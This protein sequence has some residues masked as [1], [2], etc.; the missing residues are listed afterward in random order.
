MLTL[1]HRKDGPPCQLV[2]YEAINGK[3]TTSRCLPVSEKYKKTEYKK[4]ML[5]NTDD[6]EYLEYGALGLIILDIILNIYKLYIQRINTLQIIANANAN[7]NL[8]DNTPTAQRRNS[9]YA[10]QMT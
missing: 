10:I 4:Q 6:I 8:N 7:A 2:V 9:Q 1:L 5:N 3:T